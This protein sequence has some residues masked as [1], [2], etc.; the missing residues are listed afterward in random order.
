[1]ETITTDKGEVL[2]AIPSVKCIEITGG[3]SWA[4]VHF[5]KEGCFKNCEYYKTCEEY[6]QYVSCSGLYECCLLARKKAE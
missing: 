6:K 4:G 3:K 2:I 1:M 5:S